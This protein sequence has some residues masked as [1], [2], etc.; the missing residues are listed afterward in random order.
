MLL[1]VSERVDCAPLAGR[2][3]KGLYAC[4]VVSVAVDEDAVHDVNGLAFA[5]HLFVFSAEGYECS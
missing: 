2:V 5:V 1:A 4:F 3:P